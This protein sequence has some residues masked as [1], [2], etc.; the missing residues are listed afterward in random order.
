MSSLSR[1]KLYVTVQYGQLTHSTLMFND[2]HVSYYM[3]IFYIG[4]NLER[5]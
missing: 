4:A 2:A 3:R 5:S 1:R